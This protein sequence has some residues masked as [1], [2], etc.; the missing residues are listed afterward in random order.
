MSGCQ[1][2]SYRNHSAGRASLA[3]GRARL[4]FSGFSGHLGSE[5][6]VSTGAGAEAVFLKSFTLASSDVV[7]RMSSFAGLLR[8]MKKMVPE[9][10]SF[11]ST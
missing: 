10:P 11:L 1:R 4:F 6:A 9:T 5:T 2:A 8:N 3:E 7:T